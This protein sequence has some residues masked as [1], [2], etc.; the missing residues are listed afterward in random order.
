MATFCDSCGKFLQ[1]G[2]TCPSCKPRILIEEPNPIE[3]PMDNQTEKPTNINE[4]SEKKIESFEF[5]Q[6]Y[7]APLKINKKLAII[8]A[9][10]IFV[11]IALLIYGSTQ[12][13]P[14][15]SAKNA[16]T[17][18]FNKDAEDFL[19]NV[20]ITTAMKEGSLTNDTQSALNGQNFTNYDKNS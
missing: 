18:Y 1:D 15:M 10:F 12:F 6:E 7:S 11:F 14:E 8:V 20:Y 17:A 3:P 19:A 13:T 9:S 16:L 2:E 5:H 4:E